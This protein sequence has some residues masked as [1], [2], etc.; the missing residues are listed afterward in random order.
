[1]TNRRATP[2]ERFDAKVQFIGP[3]P[4]GQSEPC[5]L[6][7]GT[8][9]TKGYGT[10]WT[11]SKQ[12]LVHRWNYERHVG[13]IPA[14]HQVDHLCKVR[15]CVNPTHLEAVTGAV[16]NARS[17]SPTALNARMEVCKFGHPLTP[18]NLHPCYTR[19]GQR[20]C[21]ICVKQRQA[22]YRERKRQ[23]KQRES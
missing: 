14:R 5:W 19:M 23:R 4:N 20:R 18:E 11:G 21:W 10:F 8:K 2:A 3:V 7:L 9:T 15:N 6:W 22:E 12:A 16:N 1:M 13:P 17:E